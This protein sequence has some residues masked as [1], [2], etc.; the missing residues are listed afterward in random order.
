MQIADS[1]SNTFLLLALRLPGARPE[2]MILVQDAD[3]QLSPDFIERATGHLG[4]DRRLGSVGGVF[5]G[6]Q[7]R[8]FCGSLAA[9]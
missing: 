3:S 9:E 7:G 6:G 1:F 2:G 5:R 4:A 8:W